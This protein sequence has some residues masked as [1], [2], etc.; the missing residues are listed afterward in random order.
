MSKKDFVLDLLLA[1]IKTNMDEQIENAKKELDETRQ[2]KAELDSKIFGIE[3]DRWS[4]Y[5]TILPDTAYVR[6]RRR[7][8]RTMSEQLDDIA[9]EG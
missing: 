8:E 1:D 2:L 6:L 7:Q 4:E 3:Q 9:A 5:E